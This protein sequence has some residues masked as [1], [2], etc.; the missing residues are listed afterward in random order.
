[1]SPGKKLNTLSPAR[2]ERTGRSLLGFD[3]YVLDQV[4][5]LGDKDPPR[6][7]EISPERATYTQCI[8]N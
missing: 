7:T 8:A 3:L 6:V 2:A 1:M 5:Q 4:T